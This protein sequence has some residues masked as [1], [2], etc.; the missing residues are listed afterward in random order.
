MVVDSLLG[1]TS[2]ATGRL[3]RFYV[4]RSLSKVKAYAHIFIEIHS[5]N[6]TMQLPI[7]R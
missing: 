1:V 4:G 7:G 2:G 3:R 6:K 5:M